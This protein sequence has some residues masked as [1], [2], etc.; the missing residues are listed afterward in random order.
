MAR[1]SLGPGTGQ[2]PAKRPRRVSQPPPRSENVGQGGQM[3]RARRFEHTPQYRKAVTDTFDAQKPADKVK[4]LAVAQRTPHLPA[5]NAI[6]HHVRA[7]GGPK[8]PTSTTTCGGR[9]RTTPRTRRTC[10]T[11]RF[12]RASSAQILTHPSGATRGLE[13]M[14]A[15]GRRSPLKLAKGCRDRRS[16]SQ[17]GAVAG[18]TVTGTA[19]ILAG[20]PA[21]VAK[22]AVG[23]V[24]HP[25]ATWSKFAKGFGA[26]R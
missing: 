2:Q 14:A 6:I 3:R 25:G 5:S 21:G 22:L 20:I 16:L 4:I 17:P 13:G 11:G 19:D 10:A 1:I 9:P 12:C 7:A 24:T 26:G 23:G 18:K 8:A 15:N